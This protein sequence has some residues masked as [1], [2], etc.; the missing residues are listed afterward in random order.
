MDEAF[1]DRESR[2]ALHLPGEAV[3]RLYGGGGSP[4]RRT[5]LFGRP[6]QP[7]KVMILPSAA[8]VHLTELERPFFLLKRC[9]RSDGVT[10]PVAANR[11]TMGM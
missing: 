1:R 6:S 2:F 10:T 3:L 8:P 9:S 7:V 5:F 4:R 11:H